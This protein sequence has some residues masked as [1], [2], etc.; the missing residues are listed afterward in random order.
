ML[1]LN[2]LRAVPVQTFRTPI[3]Q[4]VVQF[5]LYYRPA[6]QM[7]MIDIIFGAFIVN[8]LRVCNSP[9][10]LEQFTEIIPFGI[11]VNTETVGYEP[12]LIDDFSTGRAVLNVLD[13]DE[14]QQIENTYIELRG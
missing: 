9:N 8:G 4:G 6:I 13:S 11:Q 2:G 3:E 10:I 12:T 7:W 1:R 14:L 5:K